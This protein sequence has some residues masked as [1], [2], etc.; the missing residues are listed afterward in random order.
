MAR[1]H[2]HPAPPPVAHAEHA[3]AGFRGNKRH[4][5][6]KPCAACG[7][8]MSWRKAWARNWEQ[9]RWCSQACRKAGAR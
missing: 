6:T 8:P 1:P 3:A 4:L 2:R 7:R 9:V 5:P